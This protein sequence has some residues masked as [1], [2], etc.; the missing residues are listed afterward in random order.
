MIYGKDEIQLFKRVVKIEKFFNLVL[1][2]PIL[3]IINKSQA[4]F[5]AKSSCERLIK[6]GK[7]GHNYLLTNDTTIDIQPSF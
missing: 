7:E 6:I 5:Y 2:C 1:I 4:I 3:H